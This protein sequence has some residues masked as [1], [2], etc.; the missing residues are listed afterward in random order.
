MAVKAPPDPL[1]QHPLPAQHAPNHRPKH[2]GRRARIAGG[3]LMLLVV[4]AAGAA[5]GPAPAT[6]LQ[7]A[8]D[9]RANYRYDVALRWYAAASSQ[10]PYDPQPWCLSGDVFM[11]QQQWQPAVSAYERCLALDPA[12]AHG[13]L[14]L[15]DARNAQH[16]QT[17]A[18]AAW[19]RAADAGDADGATP[20]RACG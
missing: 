7:A 12:D 5:T 10:T 13:W 3:V 14:G 8:A 6:Y 2:A 16:D 9:A 11:L 20:T 4:L 18:L 17:G 15:G 19:Q 1:H